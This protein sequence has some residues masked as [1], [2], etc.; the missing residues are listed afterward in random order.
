MPALMKVKDIVSQAALEVGIVQKPVSSVVGSADQDVTQMLA[1]MSAVADEVLLE[2]PYRATLGDGV[3][4]ADSAGNPK[5]APT[6][7]GD[8]ILFDG[9]LAVDGL[10]YRFKKE[11]GLEFGEDMRDFLTRMA[12]LSARV[13]GRVL[14]LD[15]DEGRIV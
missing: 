9:R 7:D 8:V 4:V 13:N 12:K 14:D 11:K 6:T 3:W 1:L 5:P 10:K 15:A 2:E